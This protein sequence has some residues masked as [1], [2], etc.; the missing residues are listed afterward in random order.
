MIGILLTI[1]LGGLAGLIASKLMNRDGDMGILANVLV[2]ILG[3]FL[4]NLLFAG[5]AGQEARLDQ[6]SIGGFLMAVF[7]AVVLLAIVNLF[8]R[9]SL[10]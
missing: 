10:R 4:A 2:G 7:G 3:A 8:T 9:K 6:L 5:L 1:V